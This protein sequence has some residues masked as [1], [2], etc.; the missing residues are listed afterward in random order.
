MRAKLSRGLVIAMWLM[1]IPG[2]AVA[3]QS[4]PGA[5]Y[6]MSNDP[7]GNAVLVFARAA[8]GT[9]TPT[10]TVPTGGLGTGGGLGNQGGVVLSPDQRWLFV[11]NAGSNSVSVF[12]VT[13]DGVALVDQIASGG[14]LPVSVALDRDLLYVLNA[15][16][17][18]NVAGFRVGPHGTLSP[19][20]GSTRPL[21]ADATGPAQVGFS[22]DGRV[23]LVT[24]KATNTLDVFT[25]GRDGRLAGPIPYPSAAPTPFGFA[26]GKRNHLF[27]SE[28][29]GGQADQSS[30]SSYRVVANGALEIVSVAVPTTETAA[31]WVVVTPSGRFAY[32]TNANSGTLSGLAIAFD[33]SLTLRDADGRTGVTGPGSAPIDMALSGDGQHLYTLNSG[34]HSLGAFRVHAD[35]GLTPLPALGGLPG[36]ANGLAAR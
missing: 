4:A 17:V 18:N 11:V 26:F 12:A 20:P 24:E 25:V 22:P 35:G 33:G 28:A 34:T 5:V 19:V 8:N 9:L 32:T 6:T 1:S 27:V 36:G 15:G 2:V 30:V 23:L 10:A 7:S 14:E 16:G 31:C 3:G 21:S 29:A 13:Q